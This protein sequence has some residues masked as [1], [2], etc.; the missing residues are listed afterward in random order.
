LV[1]PP[2]LFERESYRQPSLPI[3]LVD[4]LRAVFLGAAQ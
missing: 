2:T 4:Y 3:I 1:S